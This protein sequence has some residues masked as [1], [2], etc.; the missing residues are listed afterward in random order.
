MDNGMLMM[1]AAGLILNCL[2][3]YVIINA[4]THSDKRKRLAEAQFKIISEM[5]ILQGVPA[6]TIDGIKSF[7][8]L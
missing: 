8:K 1:I 7:H 6:E 2:L 3:I 5:A 4:A